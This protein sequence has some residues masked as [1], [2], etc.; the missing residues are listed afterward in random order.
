MEYPYSFWP[1]SL[2]MAKTHFLS[3]ASRLKQSTFDCCSHVSR[4]VMQEWIAILMRL[5][6]HVSF[7]VCCLT[8]TLKFT[9][10]HLSHLIFMS[11]VETVACLAPWKDCGIWRTVFFGTSV[12][13]SPGISSLVLGDSGLINWENVTVNFSFNLIWLKIPTWQR[14]FAYMWSH[15]GPH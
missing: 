2:S 9:C 12:E 10:R 8:T 6:A 14:W 15:S 11:R 7:H 5:S 13:C 3:M 1:C 4:V